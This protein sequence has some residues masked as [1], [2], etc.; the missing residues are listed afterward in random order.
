MRGYKAYRFFNLINSWKIFD[1]NILI[2]QA[3][4]QCFLKEQLK[5]SRF[6][7]AKMAERGLIF[8]VIFNFHLKNSE[9]TVQVCL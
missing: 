7:K 8:D 1:A 3:S 5:I 4:A 9:E 6:K 2:D